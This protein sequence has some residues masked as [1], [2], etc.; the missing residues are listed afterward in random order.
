MTY[1]RLISTKILLIFFCISLLM[2]YSGCNNV[3]TYEGRVIEVDFQNMDDI[4]DEEWIEVDGIRYT[5]YE[6][7]QKV[8]KDEYSVPASRE[9]Y[10]LVKGDN[11]NVK[12]FAPVSDF[13]IAIALGNFI[14]LA[15]SKRD[16]TLARVKINQRYLMHTFGKLVLQ[17]PDSTEFTVR[18]S[19]D[20]PA[21]I[22]VKSR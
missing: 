2:F 15:H 13:T 20:Y 19:K 7:F 14:D 18:T 22:T 16:T 10:Y 5:H 17:R 8:Y 6:H 21:D 11:Q 1:S 9:V 4:Q 3:Q 12:K